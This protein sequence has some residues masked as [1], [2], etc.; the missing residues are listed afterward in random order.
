MLFWRCLFNR[1]GRLF[2]PAETFIREPERVRVSTTLEHQSSLSKTLKRHSIA[3]ARFNQRSTIR[4]SIGRGTASLMVIDS[5]GFRYQLDSS[6]N[7]VPIFGHVRDE[8]D[9]GVDCDLT[10]RCR[11]R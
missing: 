7:S 1:L 9:D 11:R 6:H 8:I 2:T 3:S 5:S 10:A 4:Y